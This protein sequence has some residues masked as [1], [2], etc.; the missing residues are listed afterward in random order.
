[1]WTR[2]TSSALLA[3][4]TF[5][6]VGLPCSGCDSDDSERQ[7]DDCGG[8][9]AGKA[10]IDEQCV[11]IESG[12]VWTDPTTDLT[13]QNPPPKVLMEVEDGKQYCALLEVAGGGWHLPTI[14]ELRTLIRGCAET[15]AGGACNVEEGT[16]LSTA[17]MDEAC[18][19]CIYDGG[20][21]ER[22]VSLSYSLNM[23]WPE[24]LLGDCCWYWSSSGDSYGAWHVDFDNGEV[25]YDENDYDR[26]VRCVR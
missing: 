7:S 16:C 17:C 20:P 22:R 2:T 10:C 14:G 8:C 5:V 26:N 1:M 12:G 18:E 25:E 24:E 6:V 9:S 19:G 4:A 3:V 11:E 21:S 23:Y 13:W 15:E